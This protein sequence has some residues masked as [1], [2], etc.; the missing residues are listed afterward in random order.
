MKLPEIVSPV[1]EIELPASKKQ[2][3]YR[4]FVVKEE[5]II[6]L[7]MQDKKNIAQNMIESIKQVLQNVT[8]GEVDIDA[9]PKVDVEYLLLQLRAK[10][11][12]EIITLKFSC[13]KNEEDENGNVVV[14]DG[15]PKACGKS[16]AVKFDLNDVQVIREKEVSDLVMFSD[17]IGIKLKYPAYNVT[18]KLLAF[19]DKK[20]KKSQFD[21]SEELIYECTE[22]VMDGENISTKKDFTKEEFFEFFESLPTD[23]KHKIEEYFESLPKLRGVVEYTCACGKYSDKITVE[24]LESFLA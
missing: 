8:F 21:L 15:M 23:A 4:S 18:K 24:G 7:A 13:T 3:K 12:G 10:S 17:K 9:L 5:K 1:Y 14:I 22:Y 11:K 20:Q 2:I 16:K 6:L 19:I